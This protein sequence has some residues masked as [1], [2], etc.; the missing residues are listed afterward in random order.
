V[1]LLDLA[2]GNVSRGALTSSDAKGSVSHDT[3]LPEG[4]KFMST[5]TQEPTYTAHEAYEEHFSRLAEM[6]ETWVIGEALPKLI[7]AEQ[8]C[9]SMSRAA[10]KEEQR[11]A[12]ERVLKVIRGALDPL[13]FEQLR[14]AAAIFSDFA[15]AFEPRA[16]G[17]GA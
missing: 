5:S 10:Q 11:E 3:F 6:V 17:E 7:A 2:D 8:I 15:L 14:D 1:R 9:L 12:A 13:A 16:V 4:G